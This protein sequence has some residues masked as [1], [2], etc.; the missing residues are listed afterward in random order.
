[1]EFKKA[2]WE[3]YREPHKT[4][5]QSTVTTNGRINYII[6]QITNIIKD[7]AEANISYKKQKENINAPWWNEDCGKVGKEANKNATE[8]KRIIQNLREQEPQHEEQ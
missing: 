8:M 1:M 5:T 7:A 2:D 3:N 4:T 6:T